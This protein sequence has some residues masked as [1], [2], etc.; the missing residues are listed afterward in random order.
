MNKTSCKYCDMKNI[1]TW[2]KYVKLFWIPLLWNSQY[3]Y[4]SSSYIYSPSKCYC[5]YW[6]FFINKFL[7]CKVCYVNIWCS[8]T[9]PKKYEKIS[10][11]SSIFGLIKFWNHTNCKCRSTRYCNCKK[12]NIS[13]K[14]RLLARK[15][16][17]YRRNRTT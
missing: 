9:N 15:H 4:Y 17:H 14:K 6:W 5:N 11:K 2:S 7:V 12:K 10:S 3:I 8:S 13:C 16:I 1:M